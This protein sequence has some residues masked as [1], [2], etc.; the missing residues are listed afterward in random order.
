MDVWY[1]TRA[2][3]ATDFSAISAEQ[4]FNP[5]IERGTHPEK[6]Q[7]KAL[8]QAGELPSVLIPR[9]QTACMPLM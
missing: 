3:P 4:T 1:D 6:Y 8:F 5:A 9:T 7:D 2:T